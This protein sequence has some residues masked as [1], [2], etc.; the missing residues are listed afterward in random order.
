MNNNQ[1]LKKDNIKMIW[2]V[3]SDE[4]IFKFLPRDSQSKVSDVFLNNIQGFFETEGKINTNLIDINKKYILLVL[5][6]IKKNFPTNVPN[7]IKI[8]NEM[9]VKELITYEEFQNDRKTQFEKDFVKRQQEFTNA[10]ALDIPP[11]PE[12]TDKYEEAPIIEM[13]KTIKEIIAKRNYEVDNFN[14]MYNS[15]TSNSSNWLKSQ[16]TSVKTEKLANQKITQQNTNNTNQIKNVTWGNTTE[17]SDNIFDDNIFNK[18]KKVNKQ[19][20]NIQKPNIQEYIRENDNIILTIEESNRIPIIQESI[21]NIEKI[22]KNKIEILE[23][24]VKNLNNKLDI[25]I[26]L[27]NKTK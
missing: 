4:D 12:F 21:Q 18:L 15:D 14:S 23:N 19:E 26:E 10:M 17:I 6:Y 16:E 27:L 13:E 8:L 1:F 11:V 20:D 22:N 7:K 3:I 9:P 25:I 2:D 24:E 5:T